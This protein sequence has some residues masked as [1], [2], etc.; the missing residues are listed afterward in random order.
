MMIENISVLTNKESEPVQKPTPKPTPP[1]GLHPQIAMMDEDKPT[2]P[3]NRSRT[4]FVE[5]N[6]HLTQRPFAEALRD[7]KPQNN[8]PRDPRVK[9]EIRRVTA[10]MR[11][12]RA[13]RQG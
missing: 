4:G 11:N 6:D 3:K 5:P 2:P 7:F 9:S 8:T 13:K 1:K 12:P 10:G